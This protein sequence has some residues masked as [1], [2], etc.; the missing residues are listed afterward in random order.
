LNGGVTSGGRAALGLV[1][2][3]VL[4]A[5]LVLVTAACGA[6]R[7]PG[8][9]P[10]GVGTV[11]GS[12]YALPCYP[13]AQPIGLPAAQV[14]PQCVNP[15]VPVAQAVPLCASPCIPIAQ[16][17]DQA[18][19]CVSPC[20]PVPQPAGQAPPRCPAPAV[21]GGVAILCYPAVKAAAQALP[22]CAGRPVAGLEIDFTGTD[23]T[24]QAVTDSMGRYTVTLAVGT[25][26]VHLVTPMHVISG[27][28]QVTVVSGSTLTATYI[29]DTGIRFP[30]PQQ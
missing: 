18:P 19:T 20:I 10:P 23:G 11:S 17:A 1:M 7:F 3:N 21:G 15:C 24:A 22:Q 12:V 9:T 13:V 2:K 6:Y 26:T 29:L 8:G 16:P 27:P 4:L 5:A 14:L 30:V 25:W 28:Q